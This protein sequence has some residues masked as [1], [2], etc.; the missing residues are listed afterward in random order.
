M[1]AGLISHPMETPTTGTQ[2]IIIDEAT[3]IAGNHL[4]FKGQKIQL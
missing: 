2:P 4:N 1:V 3:S